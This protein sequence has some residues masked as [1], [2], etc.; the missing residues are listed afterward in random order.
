MLMFYGLHFKKFC[1]LIFLRRKESISNPENFSAEFFKVCNFTRLIYVAKLHDVY[2]FYFIYFMMPYLCSGS[3]LGLECPFLCNPVTILHILLS[4]FPGRSFCVSLWD[5]LSSA[6][7]SH[8][9]YQHLNLI[10]LHILLVVLV[11]GSPHPQR[12]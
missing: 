5:F 8:I 6:F 3:F 4:T 10:L 11:P 7:Y 12:L 2:M 1:F 9:I